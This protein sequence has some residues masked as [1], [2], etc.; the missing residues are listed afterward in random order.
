MKLLAI[1]KKYSRP[2]DRQPLWMDA[3]YVSSTSGVVWQYSDGKVYL[4]VYMYMETL[5]VFGQ[6]IVHCSLLC[7]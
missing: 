7:H 1:I 4:N 6:A 3:H 5:S 2:N